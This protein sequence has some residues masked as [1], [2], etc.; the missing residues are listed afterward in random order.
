MTT[1]EFPTDPLR[2]LWFLVRLT[3][4]SGGAIA[5][6]TA[7]TLSSF[8]ADGGVGPAALVAAVLFLATATWDAVF[9]ARR[10]RM[11]RSGRGVPPRF[12]ALDSQGVVLGFVLLSGIYAVAPAG[13]TGWRVAVAVVVGLALLVLLVAKRRFALRRDDLRAGVE[14]A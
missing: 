4:M 10:R 11:V 5:F 7:Y 12:D 8:D 9:L 2:G 13:S 6:L 3:L 1:T 14:G